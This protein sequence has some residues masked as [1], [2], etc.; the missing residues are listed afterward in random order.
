[1]LSNIKAYQSETAIQ[2]SPYDRVLNMREDT[3]MELFWILQNF[4]H[5]RFLHMQTLH[6]VLNMPEYG[7][8]TPYYRV[9]NMLSQSFTGL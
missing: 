7:L 4:E 5:A 8:I 1:M 6:K 9:L 2:H 3:V